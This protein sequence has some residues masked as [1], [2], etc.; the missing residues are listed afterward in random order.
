MKSTFSLAAC[1]A[2][3]IGLGAV[4]SF[5]PNAGRILPWT[6]SYSFSLLPRRLAKPFIGTSN[7]RTRQT[8]VF[9]ST[10]TSP[11]EQLSGEC[12]A[13]LMIAE[14]LGRGYGIGS[15]QNELL[16]VGVVSK[17][18]RA[19]ETLN[20]YGFTKQSVEAAV[21]KLM[22]LM[23]TSQDLPAQLPLS[24]DTRR[25]LD[26]AMNIADHLGSRSIR[27]E[28]VVLALMGYNYG[29]LI[30]SAPIFPVLNTIQGLEKEFRCFKFCQDLEQSLINQPNEDA[31]SPGKDRRV[32]V[33]G[34]QQVTGATLAQ[35]GVDLTQRAMEG[36]LDRVYG[37]D[38]EIVSALRTL[39][40]RRKNNPCLVGEAGTFVRFAFLFFIR[41]A[42]CRKDC[43]R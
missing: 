6:R 43:Y 8:A 23:P 11:I 31:I 13:A 10:E 36:Q 27:S 5:S 16:L 19:Q 4:E 40:R 26:Q 41:Y 20:K 35:V 28:H 34:K 14:D 32:V 21:E 1:Y 3:L 24:A 15:I 39:G 42:R 2:V 18:E 30:N 9:L 25:V 29:K 37:R 22:R 7:R 17:P 33:G 12:L 38:D